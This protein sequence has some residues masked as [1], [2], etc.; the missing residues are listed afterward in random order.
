MTKENKQTL[1]TL[2]QMTDKEFNIF[3][4]RCPMRIQLMIKGYMVDWR[5]V[6]PSWYIK[7]KGVN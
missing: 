5:E 4:A 6:L 2:E 1:K 3:L 7:L